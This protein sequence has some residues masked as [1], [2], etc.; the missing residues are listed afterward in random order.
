[1]EQ[2]RAD[3]I[4]LEL[5]NRI[6]NGTYSNG[7][8]LDEVRLAQQFDVSRTPLR[9]A[10]QKLFNSGLIELKP[11]R[12]AFVKQPDA[13]A[14]IE[15]FEVMAE[16]EAICGKLAARRITETALVQLEEAN[17][18][19]EIAL[20]NRD[21]DAYYAEN[22]RFHHIIYK[23]SG[24]SFLEQE[25]LRLHNRLRPFRRT[26]LR[27]RGRLEQSMEEHRAIVAA[28]RDGDPDKAQR[29]LHDHVAVQGEKFHL[30]IAGLKAAE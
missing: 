20:Q 28:L 10:L 2:R 30:L 4:A 23:Q 11:R 9:E 26:Q 6:L 22:E 3:V 12:G 7:E 5:E 27:A 1:M 24:N 17:N 25:T 13:I 18:R 29:A 15:M 16:Q 19:C 8:R 21:A 14:L